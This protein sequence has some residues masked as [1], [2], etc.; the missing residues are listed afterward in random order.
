MCIWCV[1]GGIWG[2]FDGIWRDLSWIWG[3]KLD[4]G[5]EIGFGVFEVC[6]YK[7]M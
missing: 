6:E 1:F 3:L 5:S 2:V 4:L 7:D